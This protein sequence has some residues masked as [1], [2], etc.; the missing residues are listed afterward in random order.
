M[1]GQAT[2]AA[3]LV[4]AA[5]CGVDDPRPCCSRLAE[6]AFSSERKRM[7]VTCRLAALEGK[8]HGGGVVPEVTY[9][10]GMLEGV[11]DHCMSYQSAEGS[12]GLLPLGSGERRRVREVARRLAARGLRVLAI[13]H[14][15]SMNELTLDGIVGMA[16]PPRRGVHGGAPAAA[17]RSRIVMIT[18]DAKDT[19]V[20]I[21]GSL[22]F[23]EPHRH[24]AMAG[25]EVERILR[26]GGKG[27]A[28]GGDNGS[29]GGGDGSGESEGGMGELLQ[30][31]PSVSV[32]YRTSPRHKLAIVRALQ[33]AGEVVAMTGDGVNDA[34]ALSAADIGTCG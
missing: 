11:L 29:S 1:V 27:D 2:E 3:L 10:K 21:A 18:G 19:A 22:G 17:S 12:G 23:Y 5:K 20:A 16:D 32:F 4:A 31:I 14:G 7:Q 25:A 33:E 13:A 28:G 9:V 15:E 30:R 8:A 26:G 24:D 6:V 34:P